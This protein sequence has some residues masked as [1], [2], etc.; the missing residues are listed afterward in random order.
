MLWI[1]RNLFLAVG[2][3]VALLLLGLGLWILIGG[4]KENE[5]LPSQRLLVMAVQFAR[6]RAALVLM[7]M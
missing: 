2:G 3:L 5:E 7:R 4:M 6:G 1:K